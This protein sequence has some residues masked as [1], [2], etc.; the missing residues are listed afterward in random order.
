[1]LGRLLMPKRQRSCNIEGS[2]GQEASLSLALAVNVP[3]EPVR[4]ALGDVDE[5]EALGGGGQG[6]VWR[7]KQNGMERV[8]KVIPGDTDPARVE[9]EVRALQA[10]TS[11]RVMAFFDT[12]TVVHGRKRWPAIRGE[13]VAGRTVADRLE[14]GQRPSLHGRARMLPWRARRRR[15]DP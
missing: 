12:L 8:I 3:E 10:V 1:M 4:Q 2:S 9:R 11:P 7:V 14:T 15:G 6:R 5:L 13:Y